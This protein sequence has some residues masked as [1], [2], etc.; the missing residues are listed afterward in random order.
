MCIHVS[1]LMWKPLTQRMHRTYIAKYVVFR[2]KL[3][4]YLHRI[5]SVNDLINI[6]LLRTLL[7]FDLFLFLICNLC[8]INLRSSAIKGW[9][10]KMVL[11]C[12]SVTCICMFLLL[13]LLL[14]ARLWF[15]FLVPYKI[16]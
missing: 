11:K 3:N 13:L 8:L 9:W 1:V 15:F 5:R 6:T 12:C 7:F 14:S 10:P 4:H 16:D 2:K